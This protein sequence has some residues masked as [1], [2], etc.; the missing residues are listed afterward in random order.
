MSEDARIPV[1]VERR[2]YRR[3]RMA[4]AA[5]MLPLLGGLLFCLPLLWSV[6]GPP[7]TTS[8]MFYLFSIWVLLCLVSAMIS[9]RLPVDVANS[10][11]NSQNEGR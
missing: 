9:R 7:S 5:R 10:E 4:D 2:T 3:R 6:D 11:P 1:F 8:S